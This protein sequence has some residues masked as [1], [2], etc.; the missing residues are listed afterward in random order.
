MDWSNWIGV[1]RTVSQEWPKDETE[2]WVFAMI[3]LKYLVTKI[4]LLPTNY[5]PES[6]VS[7][8]DASLLLCSRL[9]PKLLSSTFV[10]L[11]KAS[12]SLVLFAIAKFNTVCPNEEKYSKN[13]KVA[14]ALGK[15]KG[16]LKGWIT[17]RKV[18]G[19]SMFGGSV[20]TRW[21]SA[22]EE[23]KVHLFFVF[24]M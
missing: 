8:V 10:E 2:K 1:I 15:L 23:I 5:R 21:W 6:L 16:S 3:K 9:R 24:I 14:G 19:G 11:L 4:C 18:I 13:E 7:M 12:F 22:E 20:N 17:D